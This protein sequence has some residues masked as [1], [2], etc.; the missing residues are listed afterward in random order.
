MREPSAEIPRVTEDANHSQYNTLASGTPSGIN[1]GGNDKSSA[2]SAIP[3]VTDEKSNKGA[4]A[5]GGLAAAGAGAGAAAYASRDDDKEK[6]VEDKPLQKDTY[7]S[8]AVPTSGGQQKVTHTCTKCGEEND[9]TSYFKD[10]KNN[11]L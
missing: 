5:T 10:K 3:A 2:T 8:S 9:I 11:V 1:V 7:T 4:Y 6:K